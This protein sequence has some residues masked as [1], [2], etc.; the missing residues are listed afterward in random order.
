LADW[1]AESGFFA[2]LRLAASGRPFWQ[3]S[4]RIVVIYPRANRAEPR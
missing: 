1:F 4:A 3:I 2:V